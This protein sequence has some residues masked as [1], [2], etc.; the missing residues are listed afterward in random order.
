MTILA[1]SAHFVLAKY[2]EVSGTGILV[3]F[4]NLKPFNLCSSACTPFLYIL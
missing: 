4:A 2:V 1:C 3:N